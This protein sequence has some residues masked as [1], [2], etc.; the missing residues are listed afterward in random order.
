MTAE[1]MKTRKSRRKRVSYPYY[2]L[3]EQEL[4]LQRTGFIAKEMLNIL[5]YVL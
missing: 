1:P 2:S 4:T 5:K 3:T